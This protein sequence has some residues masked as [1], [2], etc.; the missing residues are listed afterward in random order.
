MMK[1]LRSVFFVTLCVAMPLALLVTERP[2]R[3]V[4]PNLMLIGLAGNSMYRFASAGPGT[5]TQVPITGVVPGEEMRA[6]DFRPATGVLYGIAADASNTLLRLYI[7]NPIT[8]AARPFAAQAGPLTAGTAWGMSFNAAIDRIRVI[9]DN[10]ENARLN[11]NT[12]LLAGDDTNLTPGSIAV[13]DVAYSG[14]VQGTIFTTLYAID[15]TTDTLI[16]IGS[17]NGIPVSPNTG[18]TFT[19]GALGVNVSVDSGMDFT[20]EGVLYASVVTATVLNVLVTINPTTGAAT[21]VGTI[22]GGLTFFSS[23][24]VQ[25]PQAVHM[26]F[27][28]DG[29][30]DVAVTRFGAGGS[31]DWFV[32]RSSDSGLFATNWGFFSSDAFLPGDFDGDGK[33]DVNVW[34]SG[35]SAVFHRLHSSNGVYVG[36]QWGTIGDDPKVVGDYDGDAR[37]DHAVYRVGAT[38]NAQS[39][40]YAQL[41]SNG[42]L[43]AMPFGANDGAGGDTAAQG[44]YDGDGR[45]DFGVRRRVGGVGTFYLQQTTAGFTTVPWGLGIDSVV[46]GDWDGEGKDDIAVVRNESG[47]LVWYIRPSASPASLVAIVWGLSGDYLVPAD[48]DGDGKTD[49]AVWRPS[50]G[51]FYIRRSFDGVLIVIPWGLSTDFPVAASFVH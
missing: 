49:C 43:L 8:G 1:R 4:I 44:D 48:Y 12:G 19:V 30:A 31:A 41:S 21:T 6:I 35:A 24:A 13:H 32:H 14:Q 15:A 25:D 42:S 3:A 40:W 34:R 11:P 39:V 9:N 18:Q 27:D 17:P 36:T 16:T 29:R 33:A 51:T 20:R 10:L 38:T 26:D 50:V 22:G 2:A 37:S 7:I 46:P 47:T 5:L 23:L 45:A 28:G